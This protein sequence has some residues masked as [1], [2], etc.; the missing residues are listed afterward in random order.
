M[1]LDPLLTFLFAGPVVISRPHKILAIEGQ[2]SAVLSIMCPALEKVAAAATS[3][4]VG[5]ERKCICY[6]GRRV[7][8]V[9][10]QHIWKCTGREGCS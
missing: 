6:A 10:A 8:G 5:I 3:S 1:Q 9:L 4:V 7:M 2:L